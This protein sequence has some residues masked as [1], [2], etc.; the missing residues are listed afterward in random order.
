MPED[1]SATIKASPAALSA[2]M[3]G[4]EQIYAAVLEA[5]LAPEIFR[6][7][8][9]I[10]NAPDH[11][12]WLV[13]PP[14]SASKYVILIITLICQL[15]PNVVAPQPAKEWRE[16]RDSVVHEWDAW[17][18]NAYDFLKRHGRGAVYSIPDP[19]MNVTKFNAQI[20]FMIQLY[21]CLSKFVNFYPTFVRNNAARTRRAFPPTNG[22]SQRVQEGQGQEWRPLTDTE[23]L[24]LQRGLLRYEIFCRLIGLPSIA[25]SCNPYVCGVVTTHR[26]GPSVPHIWVLNPFSEI[27][28]IDEVEE[29]VCASIYVKDLYEGLRWN[30]VEEFSN[31]VLAL[32]QGR[33]NVVLDKDGSDTRKTVEYWLS[34]TEGQVLNFASLEKHRL[35]DWK[36]SMS[37]LGLVFLDRVAR[38]TLA[39]RR[40]FMRS[41]LNRFLSPGDTSYLWRYWGDIVHKRCTVEGLSLGVG[42]HCNS[43]IQI[44][45]NN[46]AITESMRRYRGDKLLRR[47]GWVFFDDKSK[48]RFLG[49]PRRARASA[50]RKWLNK[51]ENRGPNISPLKP[52]IPDSALAAR[53]TEQEWEDLVLK[54]YSPKDLRGDYQAMSHFVA[55]ARAVVDFTSTQLPQID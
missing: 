8:L 1:V 51:T 21:F 28:P 34:Q 15:S 23:L 47:L 26:Y 13:T 55:G 5:C 38:S 39:E 54:K 49:L 3:T 25:A 50:I 9:A 12:N 11:N 31:H 4:P 42:P 29:I 7:L 33:G 27:L 32:N 53:F 19:K 14:S 10:V 52:K 46:C 48:L 22:M 45:S 44:S 2:F 36:E 24:R 20:R 35:F 18:H 30:S 16:T 43:M 40:E 41:V 17:G 37:R 6:E